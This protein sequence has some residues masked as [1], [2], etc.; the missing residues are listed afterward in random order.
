MAP[1]ITLVWTMKEKQNA[2]EEARAR[3]GFHDVYDST[4]GVVEM[5]LPK[6]LLSLVGLFLIFGVVRENQFKT[7]ICLNAYLPPLKNKVE[8]IIYWR[9][10][11]RVGP[12]L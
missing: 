6:I 5:R 2:I 7:Q 3:A 4:I 1:S 11:V 9:L 8:E 12:Y 10:K